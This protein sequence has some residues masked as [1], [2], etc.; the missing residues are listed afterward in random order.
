MADGIRLVAA[1]GNG[2]VY[3]S[4][5]SSASWQAQGSSQNWNL[6]ATSA[7]GTKLAGAVGFGDIYTSAPTPLWSTTAGTAGWLQGRQYDSIALQYIGAGVF[8]MINEMGVGF[9]MN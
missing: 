9:A 7:D 2:Q 3:T 1:V 4:A 8:L 6:V 5:D